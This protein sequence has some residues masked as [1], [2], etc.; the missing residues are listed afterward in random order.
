MEEKVL[1]LPSAK[2][3]LPMFLVVKWAA[4]NL[5]P[6]AIEGMHNLAPIS[7]KVLRQSPTKDLIVLTLPNV[8]AH[9]A[10]NDL[11]GL[12]LLV[13]AYIYVHLQLEDRLKGVESKRDQ[14]SWDTW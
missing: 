2:E 1:L 3:F 11:P 13:C 7:A 8:P 14:E 5:V 4:L 9:Y 6:V 12:Q 10:A